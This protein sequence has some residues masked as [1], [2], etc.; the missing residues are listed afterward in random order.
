MEWN[1]AQE[2]AKQPT[3]AL[4]RAMVDE[5]LTPA[6]AAAAAAAPVRANIEET[7]ERQKKSKSQN[8]T[9][10]QRPPDPTLVQA[11]FPVPSRG[12]VCLAKVRVVGDVKDLLFFFSCSADIRVGRRL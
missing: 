4:K 11:S 6:A 12:P 9:N 3:P 5:G 1:A 8:D 10:S 2:L 7:N